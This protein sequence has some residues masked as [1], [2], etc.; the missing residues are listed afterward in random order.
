MRRAAHSK[1]DSLYRSSPV[2][3][4]ASGFEQLGHETLNQASNIRESKYDDQELKAM[5]RSPGKQHHSR[6]L[7]VWL[8][9][10][11]TWSKASS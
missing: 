3:L 6:N 2:F 8:M 11:L 7:F 4:I 5:E 1:N 9:N 10:Q